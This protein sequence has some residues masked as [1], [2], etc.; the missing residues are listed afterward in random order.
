VSPDSP[1]GQIQDLLD[2]GRFSE[3]QALLDAGADGDPVGLATA[4]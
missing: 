4:R 1:L 3:A 2:R